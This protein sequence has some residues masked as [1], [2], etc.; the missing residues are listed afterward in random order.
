MSNNYPQTHDEIQ[1]KLREDASVDAAPAKS[2]SVFRIILR[3][4][5]TAATLALFGFLFIFVISE[6][7][8]PTAPEATNPTVSDIG[9]TPDTEDSPFDILSAPPAGSN[10]TDITYRGSY[11][12][13]NAQFANDVVAVVGDAELTN[14]QLQVYYMQEI[15][16]YLSETSEPA[17]SL[18][19]GLDVQM[20]SISG[21]DM[22]WQQYFLQR[23]LTTW[24]M[25]Q[26]LA[27]DCSANDWGLN[28]SYFKYL[29]SLP[30][31]LT[32]TAE[33]LGYA[34]S[35]TMAAALMGAGTTT[36]ELVA[37]VRLYETGHSYFDHVYLKTA[38]APEEINAYSLEN[39]EKYADLT[40]D[41]VDFRHLL[42]IPADDSEK[43]WK[44]CLTQA[45]NLNYQ[46]QKKDN[47]TL[48]T[49]F[50]LEHSDD[51][52]SKNNGGLY[53]NVPEG[54][55]I[56]EIND[57]CFDSKRSYGNT[58]IIKSDIGYHVL[59]F[60]ARRSVREYKAEQD[61]IGETLAALVPQA[62]KNYP[63]KVYY[64]MIQVGSLPLSESA[65]QDNASILYRLC[66][67][68]PDSTYE[69]Y[70]SMPLYIQQDY[71]HVPYGGSDNTVVTHGCGISALAMLAS[72]M[73]DREIS[74]EECAKQF[75]SYSSKKGTSWSLFDDAPL[76]LGFYSTGR[77]QS[78]D[79]AYAALKEG[80]IVVSLQHEGFFTSGGHYLVLYSLSE[81]DKVMMR[82]SNLFNYTKKFKDTDYY[83][84]GFPVEMFIP[85]NSI[86]WIIE[87]KVTQIPACVRC[88]T[89]DVDTLT[90]SLFTGE[91]TC[92]K[93]LTALHL[94]EVYDSSCDIDALNK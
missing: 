28:D 43:A 64:Y 94:R 7:E 65:A 23:A 16:T 39:S 31:A 26:A 14:A 6:H 44:A 92:Q 88:G 59:F 93:C 80:K 13:P 11:N 79:E 41:Y 22:T 76:K 61:L 84:T 34:D 68:F 67:D 15:Y 46:L 32:Q 69:R 72:Y 60:S 51:L 56:D 77:A 17:F 52:A 75:F 53:T 4:L 57:W 36:E 20:C 40:G 54:M 45:Q 2:K 9:S 85:A 19:H 12:A 71:A 27:L 73:T 58:A 48:F 30:D 25:Y 78:W 62:M 81:D 74:L 66:Q 33:N 35:D 21:S 8:L 90:S 87:P 18:E 5:A 49:Q 42:L 37:Y 3:V 47:E 91:Y 63:L 70:T 86:C 10:L 89:E 82:D 29:N 55:F 50:V 83:Q 24:H 38:P 1:D